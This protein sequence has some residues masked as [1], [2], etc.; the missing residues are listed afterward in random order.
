[1]KNKKYQ[2]L[3]K[4]KKRV[5]GKLSKDFPRL[6]VYRSNSHI[7]AQLIDNKSSEVLAHA[8]DLKITKGTNTEKAAEVGKKIAEL[9]KKAKVSRVVFDRSGYRYHGRVK[10]LADAARD[11]GLKF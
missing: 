8:S 7:Y 10:A 1:M 9:A 6:V 4:R 5:R 11:N 3:N 2:S